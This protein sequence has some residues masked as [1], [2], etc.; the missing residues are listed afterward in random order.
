MVQRNHGHAAVFGLLDGGIV[1]DQDVEL[2]VIVAIKE[3]D[4]PGDGFDDVMLVHGAEWGF[5]EAGFFA[6]LFEVN[7][8][9]LR[10]G[11]QG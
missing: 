10:A 1:D 6:N 4:T 5:G 3:R 7:D 2:A 8:R 9:G 11:E